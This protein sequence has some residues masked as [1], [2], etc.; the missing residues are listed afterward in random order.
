[1]K[2]FAICFFVWLAFH[3]T[4]Q[5]QSFNLINQ[6]TL[7][8]SAAE[9]AYSILNSVDSS[10]IIGMDSFSGVSSDKS[11]SNYGENDAWVCKLNNNI[12]EWNYCFG[13]DKTESSVSILETNSGYVLFMY[14]NSGISGNKSLS[15]P[16][17][18]Q[19]N[20]VNNHIWMV[21]I[22]YNGNILSQRVYGGELGVIFKKAIKYNNGYLCLGTIK[23]EP[24]YDLSEST[25]SSFDYWLLFLDDNFN[26]VWDRAL[27][28]SDLEDANDF[29]VFNNE[30]YVVG[31]SLSNQSYDK[32][33]NNYSLT[34]G[35]NTWIVK[36]ND[37]GQIIWDRTIGTSGSE[38]FA[39]ITVNLSGVYIGVNTNAGSG[40]TK[41]EQGKGSDDIWVTKLN[42]NGQILADKTIGTNKADVVSGVERYNDDQIIV[43]SYTKGSQVDDLIFPSYGIEDIWI[44]MLDNNLN[45]IAQGLYGGANYEAGS[46]NILCQNDKIIF[47]SQSTSG[48]SG[49][50]N[51]PS[52]GNSDAWILQL[53]YNRTGIPGLEAQSKFEL[54]PNP[55]TGWLNVSGTFSGVNYAVNNVEGK[56]LESGKLSENINL[57]EFSDGIYFL[58]IIDSKGHKQVSKV[59]LMR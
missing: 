46:T 27:G 53:Q 58:E 3:I 9:T 14:S 31:V 36:L 59:V 45:I 55:T 47:A 35:S 42:H 8:G 32:S 13:G 41:T 57:S 22:D 40:G 5:A 51:E 30:I 43:T 20:N 15:F 19:T 10:L 18:N 26:K 23:G 48:V 44:M 52:R 29:F 1:M 50:K 17:G 34:N 4:T 11:C 12:L 37:A 2:K 39:F 16:I 7:G 24:A 21:E 6:K 49:I 28:G 33:E 54:W 56:T 38:S 25:H